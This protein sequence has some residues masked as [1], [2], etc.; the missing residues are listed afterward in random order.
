MVNAAARS[1]GP[2]GQ[3]GVAVGSSTDPGWCTLTVSLL[4]QRAM[5]YWNW[6]HGYNCEGITTAF[7]ALSVDF[8]DYHSGCPGF[9]VHAAA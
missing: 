4:T 5:C 2:G 3:V 6:T 8:T 9:M 7:T 1:I